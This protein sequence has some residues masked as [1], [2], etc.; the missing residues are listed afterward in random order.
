MQITKCKDN[1]GFGKKKI[2]DTSGLYQNQS[3]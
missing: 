1:D 3:L 2:M